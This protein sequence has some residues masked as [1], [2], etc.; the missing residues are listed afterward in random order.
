[1]QHTI[2]RTIQ[3]SHLL[4][5]SV[6]TW[7]GNPADYELKITV[8]YADCATRP[9]FRAQKI[10]MATGL[11]THID[12]PA[13]CIPG[14]KTVDQI[15]PL[16][17]V[18]PLIVIDVSHNATSGYRVTADDILRFE[19][20]YGIIS[21]HSLICLYTGWSQFW[22]EPKKYQFFPGLSAEAATLLI[23]RQ[24]YGVGIDTHSVDVLE[25]DH[26]PAHEIILGSGC[27]I[28]ENMNNLEKVPAVGATA[29]VA[30][31][32]MAGAVEAPTQVIALLPETPL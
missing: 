31:L 27:Y 12:A 15:D 30:P 1:M 13:H 26:F 19:Q 7:H 9:Q 20:R 4:H 25:G 16:N 11:G 17:F 10:S 21:P 8:D 6:P 32:M 3:L 5:P 29:L 14:G 18:A 2:Q 22:T 28:V 23:E 24:P